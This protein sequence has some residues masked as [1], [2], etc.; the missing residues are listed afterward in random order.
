MA[1]PPY[2]SDPRPLWPLWNPRS[3]VLVGEGL[4]DAIWDALP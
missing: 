3:I 1:V 2:P 4:A